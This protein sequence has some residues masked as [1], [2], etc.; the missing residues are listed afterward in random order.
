MTHLLAIDVGTTGLRA[1][2]VDDR[3][4]ILALEHRHTPP[5]TP[6]PGL[7]EFDGAAMAET[8]LDAARS[9]AQRVGGPI[10]AVGITNQRASAIV[11][12]R[13]TG[14]PIG[15]GIGWQDLR[16]VM[17]CIP[18]RAEHGWVIA[19]NQAVTKLAWLLGNTPGL[20]GRD[21]CFGTVDSWVAWTLSGGNWSDENG[22][23]FTFL[24]YYVDMAKKLEKMGAHI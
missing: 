7:V 18:A 15:P 3:L 21:L 1:A 13:S 6:A 4:S 24:A 20:D 23:W 2:V 10:D 8:V 22:F 12:D 5:S 16:T 9:V 19:P 14:A 17:E 11:W